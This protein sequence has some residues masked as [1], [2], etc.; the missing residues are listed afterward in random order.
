MAFAE[1]SFRRH[2]REGGN[3]I[4]AGMTAWEIPRITTMLKEPSFVDAVHSY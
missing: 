2:A 4:F 1:S 3:P